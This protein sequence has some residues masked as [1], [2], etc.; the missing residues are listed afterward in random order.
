[1]PTKYKDYVL[2]A[3]E[4]FVEDRPP[5]T[6]SNKKKSS[7][8]YTPQT[9]KEAL[10][11][12]NPNREDWIKA[13]NL[14]LHEMIERGTLKEV[15]WREVKEANRT[16]CKSKWVY[17]VKDEA[18]GSIR[19][20]AR[21]VAKGFTQ[22]KGIDYDRTYAPTPSFFT[23]LLIVHLAYTFGWEKRI[24]DI[25]NAYQEALMNFLLYITIP[26]DLN[27]YLVHN[28]LNGTKQGALLWYM[29]VVE[30]L[31]RYGWIRSNIDHC[32]FHYKDGN[33]I[34]HLVVYVDD[35]FLVS[36][37]KETLK[38]FETY[39]EQSFK[40]VT[41]QN[42]VKKFL[43][44]QFEEHS[45]D[46]GSKYV[47]LKQ[48]DYVESKFSD[49][50]RKRYTPLPSNLENIKAEALKTGQPI[51]DRV[52]QARFIADKTRPDIAY[53][54]SFIARFAADPTQAQTVALNRILEYIYTTKEYGIKLGSENKE[55]KLVV[56]VDAN[57]N[58]EKDS[59]A[60][61]SFQ[62]YLSEDCGTVLWRSMKDKYVSLSSTQSE[63]HALLE[64]T[65]ALTWYRDLLEEFGCEQTEPTIVFQDNINVIALSNPSANDKNSKF[66]INKINFIRE[67]I[68]AGLLNLRAIIS[69]ENTSDIGT[70]SEDKSTFA[71]HTDTSLNGK[72]FNI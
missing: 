55:I 36:N 46:D 44:V 2:N 59:K 34:M 7:S 40:K 4:E 12:N 71:K 64:A 70:K 13:R 26:G 35:I 15:N 32:L 37:D 21:L 24:K 48:S 42:E 22:K 31:S 1:M 39:L 62:F 66:M 61:L 65:K 9:D 43:G 29:K 63:T 72:P 27:P 51:Y 28:N 49:F 8:I 58:T 67:A 47:I 14:E 19:F 20:K 38:R 30:V 11:P 56:Y 52:G 5:K 18:D 54:M 6:E 3:F 33:K 10:D 41:S 45:R 17:K 60:Q 53:A 57:H 50:T 69:Q 68:D 16:C 23:V 25:A